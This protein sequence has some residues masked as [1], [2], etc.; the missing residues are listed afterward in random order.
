M[1][2]IWIVAQKELKD[3]MHSKFFLYILLL[4]IISLPYLDGISNVLEEANNGA[5]P[6][7]LY[8]AGLSILN[9]LAYTLPLV[10]SMLICSI[11]AG[12]SIVADKNKRILEPLLATPLTLDQIWL[13]KSLAIALPGIACGIGISFLVFLAAN[14][15]FIV[16]AAGRFIVP[17]IFPLVTALII[18]PALVFLVV[19]LVTFL[20]LIF[21]NPRLPS[22][23]F[24]IV[25]MAIYCTTITELSLPWNFG[26]IYLGCSLLLMI[27]LLLVKRF[28]TIDKV[29]L[30]SKG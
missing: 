13:G 24:T 12:F 26:Q 30:S 7:D 25:F 27:V 10:L 17:E 4:G 19:F 2:Q 21:N 3:L 14:L 6:A 9:I 5:G 20:Q 18:S 16:P 29:I 28:L 11:F 15:F 22:L 8:L 1:D 23:I